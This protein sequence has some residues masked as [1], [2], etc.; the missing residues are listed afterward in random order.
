MFA[1]LLGK[2]VTIRLKSTSTP[3]F[4]TLLIENE[5]AIQIK[6]IDGAVYTYNKSDV[7]SGRLYQERENN[8]Y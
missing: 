2:K 3:V 1:D 7:S 6:F 8:D 5:E 4:G